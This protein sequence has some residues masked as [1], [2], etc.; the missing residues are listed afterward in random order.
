M[1]AKNL[2]VAR[3][4]Y[5]FVMHPRRN[6]LRNLH[7][8]FSYNSLVESHLPEK[9]DGSYQQDYEMKLEMEPSVIRGAMLR[10]RWG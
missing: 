10:G 4:A 6:I 3:Y 8:L 5:V 2:A 9:K 1:H 7:H